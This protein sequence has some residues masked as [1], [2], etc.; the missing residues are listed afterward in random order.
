[1]IEEMLL[2]EKASMF[3]NVTV[4]HDYDNHVKSTIVLSPP[5]Q[6]GREIDLRYM[7]A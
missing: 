5:I 3:A 2:V 1:M 7:P 4:C 6:F